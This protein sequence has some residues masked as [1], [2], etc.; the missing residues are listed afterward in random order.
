MKKAD[1]GRKEKMI[2]IVTAVVLCVVLVLGGLMIYGKAQ[3]EKVPGLTFE[4]AL[5]YTTQGKPDARI[6]V[7]VIRDGQA[8]F[9]VYGENGRILP[10]EKQH[11]NPVHAADE[12]R[13]GRGV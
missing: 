1:I 9:T 8:S 5:N 6:T 11:G 2:L 4:D 13:G 3:M 10:A 12:Q 7:G